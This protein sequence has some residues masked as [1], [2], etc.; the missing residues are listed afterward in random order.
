[1]SL[2]LQGSAFHGDVFVEHQL[3]LGRWGC[4]GFSSCLARREQAACGKVGTRRSINGP[5]S[6]APPWGI[7]AWRIGGVTTAR[8][9]R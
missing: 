2:T 6:Q 8:S 9:R 1:M 7:D 3:L 5:V 4:R